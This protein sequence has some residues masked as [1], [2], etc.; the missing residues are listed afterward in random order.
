METVPLFD[1]HG[2]AT[3]DGAWLGGR[4]GL[5][6]AA[7]RE[8]MSG[9]GF[10]G[11]LVQ[12]LPGVG[13]YDHRAFAEAALGQRGL[14][15]VAAWNGSGAES[16]TEHVVGLRRM[17]FVGVHAHP[18]LAGVGPQSPQFRALL[19][20]AGA[21]RLPVFYCAYPYADV[22]L[23]L[24]VDPLPDLAAAL[25]E[26]PEAKLVL[27]H[28]GA[29][30]ALR[31]AEFVRANPRTLLDLS[32]TMVRYAGSSLDADLAYI[33]RTLDR[34]VCIGT[35]APEY[36]HAEVRSRFEALT[37]GLPAEKRLNIAGRSLAGF[38]GLDLYP[39]EP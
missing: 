16:T 33:F 29:A 12:G 26:A 32:F 36:S 22:G 11:G 17:G 23:G 10:L 3:L 27:L 39:A 8:A 7:L 24:P 13:G 31:Y 28:G 21:A 9:A 14:H 1:S 20:A 2:G 25:R 19:R 5:T 38:L 6:F 37:A 18:R 34:R 30:E 4:P 15:P 35:D